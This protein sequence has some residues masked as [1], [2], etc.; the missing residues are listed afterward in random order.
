MPR[1]PRLQFPGAIYHV[2][3]RGNRKSSIF[4]DDIDRRKFLSVVRRAIVRYNVRCYAF[5]L[6]GNHYHLVLETPRGNLSDG[7]RYMNGVYSQAS[8]R[9]HGRT[10]HVFEA[11]FRSIVVQRESYLRTLSRYVVLNPVRAGLTQDP[12]AW[13]W[14]SY[15]ATA[16]IE[17]PPSFL[18]MDWID[19]AFEGRTRQ[20][21]QSEYRR[22][23]N[24][25]PTS[26]CTVDLQAMALGT[27]EFEAKVQQAAKEKDGQRALP[28][29]VA[30]PQL[31][32]VF[33]DRQHSQEE[34]DQLIRSAH[35]T[36]GCS[37]AEISRFLGLHPGTASRAL[38]RYENR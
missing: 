6:M 23:V 2:M 7:M 17:G 29:P 1:R 34:R 33:G 15:R 18:H 35:V 16:G 30:A 10:G 13:R 26:S 27:P 28:R 9:R 11:R 21:A 22:F 3:A 37:L 19:W 36:Y 31:H 12:S 14:S 38:R 24:G 5:C 4:D 8:N 25:A 20:E 32:E